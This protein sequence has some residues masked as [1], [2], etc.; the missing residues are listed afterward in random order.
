MEKCQ[1]LSKVTNVEKFY[2][3][4]ILFGKT[5]Q[6]H[7]GLLSGLGGTCANSIRQDK[8]RDDMRC[9]TRVSFWTPAL[10]YRL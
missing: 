7:M 3:T 1:P 6:H 9:P 10:E 5:P 8:K 4:Q 2:K